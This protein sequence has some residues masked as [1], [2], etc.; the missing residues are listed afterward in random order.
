MIDKLRNDIAAQQAEKK[1]D[2][3]EQTKDYEE[4]VRD[5]QQSR[6]VKKEDVTNKSAAAGRAK[7]VLNAVKKKKTEALTEQGTILNKVE[8]VHANCNFIM[9]NME[10]ELKQELTR[11]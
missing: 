10:Q 8:A 3:Q 6:Q 7:E 1:R 5:S 2:N 9:E 4:F 11:S